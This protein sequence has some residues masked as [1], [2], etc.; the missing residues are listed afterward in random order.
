MEPAALIAGAERSRR[1]LGPAGPRHRQHAALGP[2]H[3]RDREPGRGGELQAVALEPRPVERGFAA[4]PGV[5]DQH[6]VGRER[7]HVEEPEAADLRHR[8]VHDDR[9]RQAVRGRERELHAHE[10][11]I[12]GTAIAAAVALWAASIDDQIRGQ[13]LPGLELDAIGEHRP[14]GNPAAQRRA[15][16]APEHLGECGRQHR[17]ARP[18]VGLAQDPLAA[19][20]PDGIAIPAVR[21][22]RIDHARQLC[23]HVAGV[24]A[25]RMVA[26][27]RVRALDHRDAQI[28]PCLEHRQ[29]DQTVLQPA[30]DQHD[31]EPR[32]SRGAGCVVVR[33]HGRPLAPTRCKRGAPA[34]HARR[35]ETRGGLRRQR[36]AVRRSTCR[37]SMRPQSPC[38]ERRPATVARIQ[39]VLAAQPRRHATEVGGSQCRRLSAA[40]PGARKMRVIRPIPR[41][42]SP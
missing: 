13:H 3:A 24:K 36:P 8:R 33:D 19:R 16:R 9:A 1:C 11:L 5:L 41:Y 38:E 28:G 14:G 10:L 34:R 15:R 7:Q 22:D 12:A 2:D 40:D 29:R 26:A 25:P 17:R 18:G 23:R 35:R 30:P 31:I 27:D 42:R 32:H 4:E 37:R 21:R 20:E 39:A 6:A